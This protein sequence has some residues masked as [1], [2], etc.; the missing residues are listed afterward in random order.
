MTRL[1]RSRAMSE[2]K[3]HLGDCL[4]F[5]KSM[6]D[7]SVDLTVT[8]PPYDNLRK[9]NGYVFDFEGIARQLYRV[10]KDG[11]V[12]VWVVADA[13]VNGSE[14]GTSFGQALFFKEI[15]F[16]LHDTMIWEKT[17]QGAVGS[18]YCYWQNFEYMFVFSKGKLQT[19]NPIE[20][21][22]NVYK[23]SK[24]VHG[25][26]KTDGASHSRKM[27]KH[28]AFGRRFNIWRIVPE[29][30]PIH[31]AVFPGQLAGDHILSW[32]NEGDLV[33][34]PF[35][36][37]G[38][39]GEMAVKYRRNFVGSEISSEYLAVAEKRIAEAEKQTRM[40]IR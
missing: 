38:T 32:S 3:L 7:K 8:S 33:F 31:K 2:V 17:G 5:M 25:S 22:E 30:N 13:T 19:F 12:V 40:S 15:G 35:M 14:T 21:R 36:G 11:G 1:C 9:Y 24:F 6:P 18:N 29:S 4:E 20:D 10:T 28:N 34:D 26:R 16:N 39:T 37:S 27:L 23:G